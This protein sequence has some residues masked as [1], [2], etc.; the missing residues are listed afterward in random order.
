MD[1]NNDK[2]TIEEFK[3]KERIKAFFESKISVHI[4][5][6]NKEWFNGQ[7]ISMREKF[8]I[9]D[10]RKKGPVPILYSDIYSIDKLD[11]LVKVEDE[12][13]GDG[14]LP[15]EKEKAGWK[16]PRSSR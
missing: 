15:E 6:F 13:I 9:L 3:N 14:I 2:T 7:I 12:F 8:F 16:K 5:M 10:E 11:E 4:G 1:D